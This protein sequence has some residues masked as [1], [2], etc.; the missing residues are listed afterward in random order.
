MVYETW[1][2]IHG[3]NDSGKILPLAPATVPGGG[4]EEVPDFLTHLAGLVKY[5]LAKKGGKTRISELAVA[6]AQRESTIRLGLEWLSAGG[7][8]VVEVDGDEVL[9]TKNDEGGTMNIKLETKYAKE[10]LFIAIKALL[11]ETVAFRRL[12]GKIATNEFVA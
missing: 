6:T 4:F 1:I 11:A 2:S 5:A 3:G 12:F 8:V 7:Q 9:L 10:E